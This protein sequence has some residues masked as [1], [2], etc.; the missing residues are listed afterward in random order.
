MVPLIIA[1][2]FLFVVFWGGGVVY[3]RWSE[4]R[5]KRR[6]ALHCRQYGPPQQP[7]LAKQSPLCS[8]GRCRYHCGMF[9]ACEESV[10]V[11]ADKAVEEAVKRVR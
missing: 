2:T 7:C 1:L 11:M 9:C 3:D 4:A 8:D 10:D 6:L 5:V